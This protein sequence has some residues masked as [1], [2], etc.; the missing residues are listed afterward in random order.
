[1][2][3]YLRHSLANREL[4]IAGIRSPPMTTVTNTSLPPDHPVVFQQQPS[5]IQ[6]FQGPTQVHPFQPVH[7]M[8]D[9][10]APVQFQVPW[11]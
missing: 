2:L 7:P 6:Q 4:T 3:P 1:M 11:N 8:I 5:A 9:E 10:G